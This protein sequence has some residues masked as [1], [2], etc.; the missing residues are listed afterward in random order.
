MEFHPEV[1]EALKR[2][3]PVVALETTILT[4]GLPYPRNLEA[5][6]LME[7][8]IRKEGAVPAFIGVLNGVIK[9][10]FSHPEIEKL[11]EIQGEK[12]QASSLSW[13]AAKK[14]SGGATVSATCVIARACKI[15]VFA[16]GGIG[17]V[18]RGAQETFDI[19]QDLVELSRTPIAVISC[20]AKAV[21]DLPR[22]LELLETMGV[23]TVGYRTEEFPAFYTH[24]S[25]LKVPRVDTV[26]EI[27]SIMDNSWKELDTEKAILILNPPPE[28][29][30][31][32]PF[33]VEDLIKRAIVSAEKAG[34]KGKA[35]TPFL[36]EY[37]EKSSG[38]KTVETNLALAQANAK[39]AAKIARAY[40]LKVK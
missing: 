30:E 13:A 38:G 9:V 37:L 34:V 23:I 22:T 35:L 27:A 39:L 1:Q 20:G 8:A 14:Q 25:G 6:Q 12:I 36:L 3:S 5:S 29:A 11:I 2:K 40:S 33:Y 31:L 18:H 4:H 28:E 24:H 7:E 17:G 10:G 21:L 32:P 26:E 19:S 15:K 16:T